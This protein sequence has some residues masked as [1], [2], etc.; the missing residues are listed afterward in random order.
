M[1]VGVVTTDVVGGGHGCGLVP[2]NS[3]RKLVPTNSGRRLVPLDDGGWW[4]RFL[5]EARTIICG[6]QLMEQCKRFGP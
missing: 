2:T 4:P 3:G 6:C 5:Q 1:D